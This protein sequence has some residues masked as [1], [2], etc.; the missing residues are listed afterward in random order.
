MREI[1]LSKWVILNRVGSRFIFAMHWPYISEIAFIWVLS[2]RAFALSPEKKSPIA[3]Q[4]H[5][6]TNSIYRTLVRTT[7]TEGKCRRWNLI[8]IFFDRCTHCKKIS[9][10]QMLRTRSRCIEP[11]FPTVAELWPPMNGRGNRTRERA[12]ITCGRAMTIV[13]SHGRAGIRRARSK[14]TWQTNVCEGE[15]G[16]EGI[17]A[18]Q[19]NSSNMQQQ[20][21]QQGQ[22]GIV[23]YRK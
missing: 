17:R 10:A 7:C 12:F 8:V 14:F 21:Q 11:L 15:K 6:D 19:G 3:S 20:Q 18:A 4:V 22:E 9:L 1:A 16:Y 2:C 23:Y 13:V 5:E